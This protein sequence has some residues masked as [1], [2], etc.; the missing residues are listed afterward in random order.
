LLRRFFFS[1]PHMI[2]HAIHHGISF[3]GLYLVSNS[4]K[5]ETI[6][7]TAT[8]LYV[9]TLAKRVAVFIR[10]VRRIGDFSMAV[11]GT[12]TVLTGRDQRH[13]VRL[14][15]T[16]ERSGAGPVQSIHRL[17]GPHR[18]I[19]ALQLRWIET[20]LPHLLPSLLRQDGTL[21]C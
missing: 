19:K 12:L 20:Q 15:A 17:H 1:P 11:P 16:K 14:P 4:S 21:H 5:I 3:D 8:L 2:K 10:G 13:L 9:L 18:Y 7:A 6:Q